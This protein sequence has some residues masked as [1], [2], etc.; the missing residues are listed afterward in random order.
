[1]IFLSAV[2]RGIAAGESPIF[3]TGLQFPFKICPF[4]IAYRGEVSK[5][6]SLSSA[7]DEKTVQYCKRK[8]PPRKTRSFLSIFFAKLYLDVSLS[9]RI[10]FLWG[11]GRAREAVAAAAPLLLSTQKSCCSTAAVFEKGTLDSRLGESGQLR[12]GKEGTS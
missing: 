10:F 4:P 5:N 6:G 12:G 3:F 9:R 11:G 7:V 2:F 1:M 8:K